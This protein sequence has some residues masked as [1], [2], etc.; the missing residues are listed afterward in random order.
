MTAAPAPG[1]HVWS[2]PAGG[3]V[4]YADVRSWGRVWLAAGGPEGP[5]EGRRATA[6]A[7]ERAARDAGARPLWFGVERPQEIGEGRPSVVVGAEP[8]WQ[9]RRWAGVVAEKRSV[10]AQIRRAANK[11]VTARPWLAVRAQASPELRALLAA[12]LSTR[13]LP[14]LSFLASPFVLDEPGDRTFWVALVAGAPV[15]YLVLRPGDETLVEW[16]VQGRAAPNGT[17]SLLLDAAVRSLPAS[18]AFTLGLVPLST[19]ATASGPAPSWPVRA[20]LA[21]T[22]AH[23]TRFYNVDG[24]ERFKAKFVPDAWRPLWLVTDGR[25]VTVRTFHAVAAGFAAP[26][27]PARFVAPGA[28]GRARR[29]GP[30]RPAVAQFA[31]KR[32]VASAV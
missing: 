2:G 21:W 27:G 8:V 22:R 7:F 25:P 23:A 5:A 1:L 6:A 15:G 24:L 9:T 26:L 20:L 29:R 13:G 17:A 18:G 31:R 16:I 11:G 32:N 3:A 19:R 14:P 10:R 12:W 4:R 30:G 28:R